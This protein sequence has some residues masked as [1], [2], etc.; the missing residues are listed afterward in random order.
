[1]LFV[2]DQR[3]RSLKILDFG[4]AK[5]MAEGETATE[6]ATRTTSGVGAFSPRHA[7]PEQF[8]PKKFGGTGPWTDVH[9]LGLVLVEMVTGRPPIDGDTPPEWFLSATSEARPTPRRRGAVVSDG[10]EALCAR[11]LARMPK[12]RFADA[13][14]LLEAMD[15]LAGQPRIAGAK[16][17]R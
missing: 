3:G 9:A 15:A 6:E 14:A 4:I 12:D 8:F 11:A 13:R 17:A 16:G 1:N 10:F 7:A 5:A 2:V